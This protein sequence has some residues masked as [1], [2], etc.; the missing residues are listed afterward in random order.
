[1]PD[2]AAQPMRLFRV[3]TSWYPSQRLIVKAAS[4]KLAM[5]AFHEH[6]NPLVCEMNNDGKD[7][8]I[9][10]LTAADL[11]A[12]GLEIDVDTS[13]QPTTTVLTAD[14]ACE[15]VRAAMD[16]MDID[17]LARLVSYC[18]KD[19][20]VA[21]I[22]AGPYEFPDEC[23]DAWENGYCRGEYTPPI[24]ACGDD[25]AADADEDVENEGATG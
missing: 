3:S 23:S 15:A 24:G 7:D 14:E 4:K 9:E 10:E 2:P 8:D 19:G 18:A 5:A 17:Q 20:R 1:M 12:E 11:A 6:A 22:H 25:D 16:D 13:V 21:V